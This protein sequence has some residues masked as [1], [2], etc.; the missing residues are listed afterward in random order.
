[1]LFDKED[2]TINGRR[3]IAAQTQ[4]MSIKSLHNK[5]EDGVTTVLRRYG[6]TIN[7]TLLLFA[8]RK[9]ASS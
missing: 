7:I 1:M 2:S 3:E 9:Q 5:S 6:L 4:I 8:T